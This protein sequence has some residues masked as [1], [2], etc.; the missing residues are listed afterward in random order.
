M[1]GAPRKPQ[2]VRKFVRFLDSDIHEKQ[3]PDLS[4]DSRIDR[5]D[6][7]IAMT[8]EN[9][10]FAPLEHNLVFASPEYRLRPLHRT[11]HSF[12]SLVEALG[13]GILP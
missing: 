10:E 2:W 1:H 3:K 6:V 8:A 7:L 11:L 9:V 5:D 4:R 13:P 12:R